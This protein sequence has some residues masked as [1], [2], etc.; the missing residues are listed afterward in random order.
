MTYSIIARDPS[1]GTVGAAAQSHFF[2]V[3]AHVL[4]AEPGVGIVAVQMMPEPPVAPRVL[5]LLRAGASAEEA[6][7]RA[8]A[9]DAGAALRQIGLVD[10]RGVAAAYTGAQCVAYSAH[11]VG[12]GATAQA[13]M[14]RSPDTAVAMLEAFRRGSGS[15]AERLLDALDA[16][17]RSGGD[18]RGQKAAVLFVIDGAAPSQAGS[19]RLVDLRVE[20]HARPLEELRRL[21]ESHAFYASAND[22]LALALAGRLPES[23]SAFEELEAKNAD[24]PDVALRH[25]LV[26]V[27]A[28]DVHHAKRR[29]ASCYR[30]H[31]GWRTIVERLP[32][33]GLLPD[34]PALLATLL[35]S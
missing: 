28:G 10:A 22:A 2:N 17:E 18:I 15:F 31:D 1:T 33:A 30:H 35:A 29:L 3:G 24:D 5:A 4:H 19:G 25:A 16:A 9:A 23:C 21:V 27:M 11:C 14:C 13:A 12:E 8:C 20:D 34:E 6:V 26:L 7:D 32:A